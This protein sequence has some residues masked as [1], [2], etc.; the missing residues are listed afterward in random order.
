MTQTTLQISC[1]INTTDALAPL[2][3]EIRIDNQ[4]VLD[5]E[6]VTELI[7][8]KHSVSDDD[9]DHCLEFV[10][11]NKTAEHTQIDQQGNIVSDACLNISNL[12]FDEIEL[13]QIFIDH[14]VYTHNFNGSQP[15]TQQQFYGVKGCNGTVSLDFST[16]VYLWLLEHM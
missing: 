7:E 1:G 3:L 4:V 10:L 8:F 14:A 15:E 2:G 6:H 12:T 11:K 5:L 9:A 16:P 13:K